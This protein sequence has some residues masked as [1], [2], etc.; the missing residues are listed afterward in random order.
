MSTQCL[1]MYYN[2]SCVV[3]SING[4]SFICTQFYTTIH[5]INE[6]I[7]F[8]TQS[9]KVM[10]NTSDCILTNFFGSK[11]KRVWNGYS[12]FELDVS[13]V[14]TCSSFNPHSAA[15]KRG[16]VSKSYIRLRHTSRARSAWLPI[17]GRRHVGLLRLI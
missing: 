8:T 5:K 15:H 7:S 4:S 9:S 11:F 13:N 10:T 14:Y 2:Q 3:L 17:A 6:E 16:P 12:I 1:F